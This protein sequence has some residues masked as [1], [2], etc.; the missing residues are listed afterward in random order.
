MAV[1]QERFAGGTS[2][3]RV[4]DY[5]LAALLDESADEVFG[6]G[7][8]DIVDF[9]ENCI[10]VFGQ[11]LMALGDVGLRLGLDLV[12]LVL[13]LLGPA[14]AALM[15]GHRQLPLLVASSP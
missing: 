9:I 7:L 13:I 4:F 15:R 12:G 14:L 3:N 6:I 11:L 2:L 10:D 8:Q 5:L 1:D